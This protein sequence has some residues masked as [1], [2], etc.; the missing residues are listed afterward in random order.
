M[1]TPLTNYIAVAF[2]TIFEVLQLYR[3]S[4]LMLSR[5][6]VTAL[7]HHCPIII[8]LKSNLAQVLQAMPLISLSIRELQ[9]S[10]HIYLPFKPFV[11]TPLTLNCVCGVLLLVFSC[12]QLAFA[13]G[14]THQSSFWPTCQRVPSGKRRLNKRSRA[15]FSGTSSQ[16]GG[17]EA[18]V[19]WWN[20]GKG[21]SPR[22]E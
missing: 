11:S 18:G 22:R 15:E 14:N 10:I 20:D 6:Q 17:G 9:N 4:Y 16:M 3:H 19:D 2:P 13:L 21:E 5:Q 7:P 1:I 8:C 12:L